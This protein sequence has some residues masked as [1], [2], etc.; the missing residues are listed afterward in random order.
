LWACPTTPTS[1]KQTGHQKDTKENNEQQQDQEQSLGRPKHHA[2]K[3]EFAMDN[4]EQ[5]QWAPP[6]AE[7]RQNIKEKHQG[8]SDPA[9]A[10]PETP[11]R[12]PRE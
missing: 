3:R 11:L 4:I 8:V 2:C 7:P 5:N 12:K 9:A 1:A 6:H 10:A